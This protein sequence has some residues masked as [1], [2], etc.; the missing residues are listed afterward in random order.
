MSLDKEAPNT[1]YYCESS[2][3]SASLDISRIV[4]SLLKVQISCV[5]SNKSLDHLPYLTSSTAPLSSIAGDC[6][7]ARYLAKIYDSGGIISAKD[8][9]VISEINQ[10]LDIYVSIGS[11]ATTATSIPSI[12]D[13]HLATRT[14]IVGQQISLADVAMYVLCKRLAFKTSPT[15][16]HMSR[17][18]SL[19]QS[20]VPPIAPL[21]VNKSK[22]EKKGDVKE[23]TEEESCPALVDAVEGKVCTRFPPEPS[24]Y[25]HIGHCKA[26]LLNQYYAQRYKGKLLVRFDDTNPSKEKEE[27]ED[28]IIKD[29]E[30]LGVVAN[31]VLFLTLFQF[32]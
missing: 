31:K 13:S 8:E 9:W 18:F 2:K 27:F 22:V 17:W 24:G 20:I 19:I 1:L 23:E 28:N 26:V 15:H 6:T 21:K 5:A 14:Y 11:D 4:L 25:L 32:F 29:L 12:L 10:W 30:T 16:V 3:Q 7:I